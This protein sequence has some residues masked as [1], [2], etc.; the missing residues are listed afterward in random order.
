MPN[1]WHWLDNNN[2]L[3]ILF[4]L[5]AQL[6]FDTI[7][8]EAVHIS[9]IFILLFIRRQFL[10]GEAFDSCIGAA[11]I[12]GG[13]NVDGHNVNDDDDNGV[14]DKYCDSILLMTVVVG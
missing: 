9:S 10:S 13:G 4:V 6:I 11:D 3:C 7:P 8:V 2:I 14:N 12:T 1:E 5:N